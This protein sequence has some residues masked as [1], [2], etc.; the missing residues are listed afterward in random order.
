MIRHAV[1]GQYFMTLALDDAGYVFVQFMLPFPVDQRLSV[2]HG[3][4]QMEMDF[5][6]RIRHLR[7]VIEYL[8]RWVARNKMIIH[9]RGEVVL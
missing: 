5:S 2:F 7:L 9:M 4:N 3:K 6:V 1:Y 8:Q